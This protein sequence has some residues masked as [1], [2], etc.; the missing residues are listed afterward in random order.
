MSSRHEILALLHGQ[1]APTPPTFSALSTVIAPA[2]EQR[3]LAFHEIH[4]DAEKMVTAAASAYELYDFPSATLPTDLILEAE[5]MGAHVDF[6]DDMPMPMWP[7][8][9]EPPFASPAD[10]VL[11]SGD[12][13]RR[14]RIPLVIDAIGQLKQRVGKEIVVGAWIAGPFTVAN[15]LVDYQA[16]L[17]AV[18]MNPDAVRHALD[19]I[20]EGLLAVAEAY[21]RAGADFITI[22]EMGGSPGVL[23]PNV[24]GNLVLPRLQTLTRAIAAPTILSI[25]GNTNHSMELLADSG[26]TALHVEHTNNLARSREILGDRML[27]FGNLDP[28]GVI[29][30]GSVEQIRAGIAAAKT[31]GVDAVMPGCDLYLATPEENMRELLRGAE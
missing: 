13:T 19:V 2:L 12:F 24:F 4:H 9:P 20:T 21:Q 28:V 26:A 22:H 5:A 1:R 30:N 7:I 25:C 8:V 16:L 17:P 31:A 14:G 23:G 29:A 10:V 11:P 15:Y 6:R 27:L 18:R 3:K